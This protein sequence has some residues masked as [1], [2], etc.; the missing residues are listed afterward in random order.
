[1]AQFL[2]LATPYSRYAAGLDAAFIAAC[3]I[4]ASLISRGYSVYSPIAHTHPVALHGNID[5]LEHSIWLPFNASMM[6][7]SHGLIVAELPGWE[8]SVGVWH[9][10]NYFSAA[11]KLIDYLSW[12]EGEFKLGVFEKPSRESKL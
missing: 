1:M 5:P 8:S 3:E 4:T 12:P 9:E 7:A 11:G 10:S 2:Y 6:K